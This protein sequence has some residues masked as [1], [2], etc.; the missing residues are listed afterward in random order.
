M[1]VIPPAGIVTLYVVSVSLVASIEP[2][3]FTPL[4]VTPASAAGIVIITSSPT[5]AFAGVIEVTP[6]A[7]SAA[8]SGFVAAVIVSLTGVVAASFV[9]A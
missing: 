1:L 2:F 6:A 3:T 4:I 5:I 9:G 8:S 7:A